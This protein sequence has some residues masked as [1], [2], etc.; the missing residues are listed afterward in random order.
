MPRKWISIFMMATLT[1]AAAAYIIVPKLNH[2]LLGFG[3]ICIMA[4]LSITLY[5]KFTPQFS[6]PTW[7]LKLGD[8]SYAI[9]LGHIIIV[10]ALYRLAP[11]Y[12]SI[13]EITGVTRVVLMFSLTVVLAYLSFK[14]IETPFNNLGKKIQKFIFTPQNNEVSRVAQNS[15]LK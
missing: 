2:G 10:C 12:L 15:I 8:W 3:H 6:V 13:R 1:Y 11:Y 5:E 7:L 4:V 14:F 9:Y